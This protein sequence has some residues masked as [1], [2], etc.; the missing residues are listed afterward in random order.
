LQFT[1]INNVISK[2]AS[3]NVGIPQ[4]TILAPWLFNLFINDFLLS[5]DHCLNICFADDTLSLYVIPNTITTAS[6]QIVSS[7]NHTYTWFKTNLLVINSKK[8]YYTIYSTRYSQT[9]HLFFSNIS[10]FF[11][12]PSYCSNPKYLGLL[13]DTKLN[14]KFYITQ[15]L[16]KLKFMIKQSFYLSKVLDLKTKMAWYYAFVYSYLSQYSILLSNSTENLLTK[17]TW[18]Q[19]KIIKVLFEQHIAT[20]CKNLPVVM[21]SKTSFKS[22]FYISNENLIIFM[23]S[24]KLLN[25]QQIYTFN[26]LSYIKKTLLTSSVTPTTNLDNTITLIKSKIPLHFT[27]NTP[28]VQTCTHNTR[29][30]FNKLPVPYYSKTIGQNCIDFKCA[31]LYNKLPAEL[32]YITNLKSF[33]LSLKNYLL[34]NTLV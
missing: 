32:I 19:Y 3:N 28:L 31:I 26:L 22:V 15:M 1:V 14:W 7:L 30:K 6:E 13:F 9:N 20:S 16:P 27:N 2:P 12:P 8:S 11:E 34:H 24:N 33:K 17:I 5:S 25:F 23:V 21:D 10:S 29:S 18:S 4:G